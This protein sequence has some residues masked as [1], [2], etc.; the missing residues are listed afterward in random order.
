MAGLTPSVAPEDS[1][2]DGMPDDWESARGLDP[3][4]AD[5]G[6]DDDGDG[7]TNIEEYLHY[8]AD[9]LAQD[10]S[11]APSDT[12]PPSVP[13]DVAAQAVAANQID[14]LWSAAS[15][16][17]GVSG[18]RIYR[19]GSELATTTALTYADAE[20]D[21]A[22]TYTYTLAAYD[23]AGNES[24]LC[25]PVSATTLAGNDNAGQDAGDGGSGPCFIDGMQP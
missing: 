10:A 15:D 17:V 18:Y 13:G 20:L 19:D 9:Q 2:G 21:A 12:L 6:G 22:T 16:N 3:G 1:D 25:S 11:P 5:D 24:D 4:L 23:A 14:L 8:R 7:Y